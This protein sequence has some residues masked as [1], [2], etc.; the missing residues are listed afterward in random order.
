MIKSSL[1]IGLSFLTFN[2]IACPNLTG[3]FAEC[4]S[5]TGEQSNSKNVRI[6]Q[7]LSRNITTYTI[8]SH[9]DEN[10][11]EQTESFKAD[12]RIYLIS[13]RDADTGVLSE[14]K[15]KTRCV[16][17]Q[18][19]INQKFVLDGEVVADINR[20]IEKK[21]QKVIQSYSGTIGEETLSD[22]ITCQ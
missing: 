10:E 8:S 4:L 20:T 1:I 5:S 13:E 14:I 18:L 17:E 11:E 9:D 19:L 15:T 22:V 2:V 6:S 12:A 7:V 21:D 3:Q 16:G